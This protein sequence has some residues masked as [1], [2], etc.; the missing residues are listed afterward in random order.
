MCGNL[1]RYVE[2]RLVVIPQ[3]LNFDT[4][5][6]SAYDIFDKVTVLYQG[7]QIYFG[8]STDAQRYFESMGFQCPDRQTTADFLTSMTSP[9]ERERV[10][11]PGYED[12]VP[13]T[14][15]EF[16]TLWQASPER[17]QLVQ[18]IQA[19]KETHPFE[20]EHFDKFAESRKAQQAKR[21]RL[22]SPYT[23]SYSQQVGLCL[24]RGLKR[25]R[26]DPSIALG[27]LIGN[28]IMALILGS[29]FYNLPYTAGKR[30]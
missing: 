30:F 3:L 19:Y 6:Q 15:D 12:R 7:R 8:R 20:G 21:Q 28:V 16:A 27:Q 26:G 18:D 1:P 10:V 4:A 2:R 29:V 5:P 25:L 22:H 23:L 17:K 9:Q 13:R 11:M 14:P 24:W